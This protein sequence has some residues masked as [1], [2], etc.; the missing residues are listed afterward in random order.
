[1]NA[2]S[3]KSPRGVLI[4]ILR[5]LSELEFPTTTNLAVSSTVYPV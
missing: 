2:S 4:S 1:M 3:M 5:D